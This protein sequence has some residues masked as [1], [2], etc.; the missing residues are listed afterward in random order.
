LRFMYIIIGG[1]TLHYY[2]PI[3][4][5]R[6]IMS[7]IDIEIDRRRSY[8]TFKLIKFLIYANIC[9]SVH[10]VL[11]VVHTTQSTQHKETAVTVTVYINVYKYLQKLGH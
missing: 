8:A 2:R 1:S 9:L 4:R 7:Q 10:Q 6:Y 11:S 3:N 5:H